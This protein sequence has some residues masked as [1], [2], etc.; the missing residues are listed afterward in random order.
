MTES[1]EIHLCSHALTD[2]EQDA[3]STAMAQLLGLMNGALDCDARGDIAGVGT[4][5]QEACECFEATNQ[6]VLK[7]GECRVP[8][9]AHE[10]MQ[11]AAEWLSGATKRQTL[12]LSLCGPDVEQ[13]GKDALALRLEPG[14]RLSGWGV[15]WLGVCRGDHDIL[16]PL[17]IPTDEV[18]SF[19]RRGGP[20]LWEHDASQ[21]IG[22]CV[23][24]RYYPET[25]I[26]FYIELA[27]R[28]R[29]AKRVWEDVQGHRFNGL[30]AAHGSAPIAK[31]LRIAPHAYLIGTPVAL[32][33]VSIVREPD[34][35]EA[36]FV[37]GWHDPVP[38]DELTR[39][40]QDSHTA[41]EYAR[42]RLEVA[43]AWRALPETVRQDVHEKLP[44]L[45]LARLG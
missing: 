12:G 19:M 27:G 30:S 38:P 45:D 20:V 43:C 3:L 34:N 32:A 24:A 33:E 18:D 6:L 14:Y 44:M 7:L 42:K 36:R 8:A 10:A 22:R 41:D 15:T 25:G 2:D 9:K 1:E 39:L 5:L 35:D 26:W 37:H 28:N 29:A 11:H 21:V 40:G 4:I 13:L 16:T 23:R 31:R 17:A